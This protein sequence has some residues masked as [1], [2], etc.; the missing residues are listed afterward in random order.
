MRALTFEGLTV[1][2]VKLIGTDL[3]FAC[4]VPRAYTRGKRGR[5][6]VVISSE[7]Y[8]G[9]GMLHGVCACLRCG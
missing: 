6:V 2:A 5:V 8:W 7:C 1:A 4:A 9:G 3:W